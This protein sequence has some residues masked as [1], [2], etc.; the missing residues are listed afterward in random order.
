M[1]KCWHNAI[2]EVLLSVWLLFIAVFHVHTT[3]RERRTALRAFLCTAISWHPISTMISFFC[4]K[5]K[6]RI[7]FSMVFSFYC[8]VCIAMKCISA[9]LVRLQKMVF[10]ILGLYLIFCIHY[11]KRYHLGNWKLRM[12]GYHFPLESIFIFC[13]T[14][15]SLHFT[16]EFILS[17]AESANLETYILCSWIFIH[18]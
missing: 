17:S 13:G 1:D 2:I 5:W 15:S 10:Y 9:S 3:R 4:I 8:L 12:M 18:S 7:S 6:Q 11:G 14:K 16:S